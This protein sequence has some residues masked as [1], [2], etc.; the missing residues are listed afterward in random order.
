MIAQT[1]PADAP[2]DIEVVERVLGGDRAAFSV[3]VRRHNQRLY[4]AARAILHADS[5]AED[6]AQQTWLLIFRRLGTFRGDAAFATWATRIAVREALAHA[7]RRPA[8][9]EVA[10][11]AALAAAV[12][13]AASSPETAPDADVARAQLGALLEECLAG[14]P[15][16]NREVVVL[17]DVLELDTAETAACLGLTEEAVRV[18]LHRARAAVAAAVAERL[19]D[20]ARG[21]YGFA[22]ARCDR[23]TAAVMAAVTAEPIPPRELL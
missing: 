12:P 4:R 19:T 21:I 7:R 6:V 9:A 14:L 20:E 5:D 3:L 22:G 10:A 16:G 11:D 18:R 8:L 2:T 23:M 13:P 17:R 1:A 15:Q